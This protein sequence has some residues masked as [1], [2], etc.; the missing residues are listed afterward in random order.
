[1]PITPPLG[2]DD[3]DPVTLE[4]R[5]IYGDDVNPQRQPDMASGIYGQGFREKDSQDNNQTVLMEDGMK[6]PRSEPLST[7]NTQAGSDVSA[8][9]QTGGFWSP[10]ETTAEHF[11][12]GYFGQQLP[13]TTST[14][15][16]SQPTSSTSLSSLAS[17][18]DSHSLSYN[19]RSSSWRD[20]STQTAI[21]ESNRPTS[22]PNFRSQFLTQRREIEDHPVH[23]TQSFAALQ[24]Q[25]YPPPYQPH[26]LRARS[27]H[28]SQNSF[29]GSDAKPLKELPQTP[30]GAK[31]VGNTPAQ[32]PGLFSPMFSSRK[33]APD[34]DDGHYSVPTMHTAHLG[35][36]K[37]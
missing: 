15:D 26:P 25:Q 11:S 27:S 12:P 33:V 20:I 17:H 28:T 35:E 31:T 16:S 37:E 29:S 8:I 2:E 34:S 14:S 7:V 24:S 3:L 18:P 32:S 19:S 4:E 13:Q 1:M 5:T 9:V 10:S 36:P 21:P 30:S 6:T 22:V 23:Q